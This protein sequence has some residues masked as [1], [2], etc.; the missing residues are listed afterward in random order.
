MDAQPEEYPGPGRWH[1]YRLERERK[2][3]TPSPQEQTSTDHHTS[4][5]TNDN[6]NHINSDNNN[7]KI[8]NQSDQQNQ[9]QQ[10]NGQEQS[11]INGSD[12]SRAKRD[13]YCSRCRNHGVEARVKGHKRH[14]E[15]KICKCEGCR[16]VE[17]RQLVSAAQI[18]RRRNLR[19]DE[20][21]GR[22][23]EVTPPVLVVDP[24]EDPALLI[25]KTL[26]GRASMKQAHQRLSRPQI[27]GHRVGS[28]PLSIATAA[29]AAAA[30]VNTNQSMY[31]LPFSNGC[32][33]STSNPTH[34]HHQQQQLH[35]HN[36]LQEQ[37][38]QNLQPQHISPDELRAQTQYHQH[39]HQN[40]LTHAHQHAQ[41]H[42]LLSGVSTN[43]S[44]PLIPLVQH[45][46]SDTA[47][48]L[49]KQHLTQSTSI[50]QSNSSSTNVH[51]HH[52]NS[53]SS[54]SNSSLISCYGHHATPSST[55]NSS[56]TPTS[57]SCNTL[58]SSQQSLVTSQQQSIAICSTTPSSSKQPTTSTSTSTAPATSNFTINDHAH[59]SIENST[60]K[61]HLINEIH[62]KYGPLV[63]Y[64]WLEMENFDLRKVL[65]T[66]EKS[67]ASFN[68]LMN[69][70]LKH[71][72]V[73]DPPRLPISSYPSHHMVPHF[74]DHLLAQHHHNHSV[75]QQ[76]HHTN[77]NDHYQQQ[78]HNLHQQYR[79]HP[80]HQATNH[81]TSNNHLNTEDFQLHQRLINQNSNITA[82]FNSSN[83]PHRLSPSALNSASSTPTAS[84]IL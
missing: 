62:Q 30:A 76:Q 28:S 4:S 44:L 58:K 50:H 69:S 17:W 2:S 61:L 25:A 1:L 70:K 64:A 54:C 67:R 65:E 24:G 82:A 3:N 43:H 23:I 22:Q 38:Q 68:E 74:L 7:H 55:P 32:G 83:H 41:V 57:L 39:S 81:L 16:L 53:Q 11:I 10:Q 72:L 21:S 8:I 52:Q 63:L 75:Q 79:Y 51:H 27:T 80:Y 40:M 66:I 59:L 48:H 60:G 33:L 12:S 18:K 19:Q 31:L 35:H 71:L 5:S 34:H 36:H 6:N 49:T 84:T 29:A 42:P 37:Q 15:F 13:P 78:Q 45:S 9:Q 73:N 47:N 77:N 26:T 46:I 56:S 20:E 14:C